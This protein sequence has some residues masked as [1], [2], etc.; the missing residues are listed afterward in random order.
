VVSA[1]GEL[2]AAAAPVAVMDPERPLRL[3]TRPIE[4]L[5]EKVS[6]YLTTSS[7]KLAVY[8]KRMAKFRKR[9]R[10]RIQQAADYRSSV[11]AQM[12]AYNATRDD[13]QGYL[14]DAQSFYTQIDDFRLALQS[15]K[16]RRA[17]IR[18]TLAA[19]TPPASIQG[20]HQRIVAVLDHAITATDLG[21]DLADAIQNLR[22]EGDVETS[23][24]DL[25]EY[26]ELGRQSQQITNERAGAMS[27]WTHS[28]D[29]YVVTS[30]TPRARPSSPSSDRERQR[31]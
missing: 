18:A 1:L 30:N 19:L 25:P 5:T 29:A 16:S 23:A 26:A 10:K 15:A 20:E 6:R 21:V 22:D 11:L 13:L 7:R 28:M 17:G 8:E 4:A 27:N 12:G 3:Q 2:D 9:N 14:S 24:F 31:S